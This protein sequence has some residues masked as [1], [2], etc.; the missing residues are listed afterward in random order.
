MRRAAL[1]EGFGRQSGPYAVGQTPKIISRWLPTLRSQGGPIIRDCLLVTGLSLLALSD[2]VLHSPHLK[3]GL[4]MPMA[5][6]RFKG[7]LTLG[8]RAP[9][10]HRSLPVLSRHCHRVPA[11]I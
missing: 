10:S 5:A 1:F 9:S 4:A 11:E 2:W 7:G 6:H 8:C 3:Q